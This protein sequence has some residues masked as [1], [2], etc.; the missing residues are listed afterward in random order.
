MRESKRRLRAIALARHRLEVDMRIARGESFD[1][2]EDWINAL[3]LPDEAKSALWLWLWASQPADHQ[4]QVALDGLHAVG[5][6]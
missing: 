6:T 4:R 3:H 5:M 1:E 2:V